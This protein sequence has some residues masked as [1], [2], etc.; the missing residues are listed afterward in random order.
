[1][2]KGHK[3]EKK[4]L[5]GKEEELIEE[6]LEAI[7][8]KD[9]VDFTKLDRARTRLTSVLLTIVITLF[10]IAATAWIGFFVYT[11]YFAQQS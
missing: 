11:K 7:Y 10:V 1:M 8:G 2:N 3:K 6:G 9:K 5:E 4:E